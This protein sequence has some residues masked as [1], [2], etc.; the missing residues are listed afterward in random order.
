[1]HGYSLHHFVI[2]NDWNHLP[3]P[4]FRISDVSNILKEHKD[5]IFTV[6]TT[7]QPKEKLSKERESHSTCTNKI[8]SWKA[9]PWTKG[10]TN[11]CG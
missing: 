5:L 9:K 8:I 2:T 11:H 3:F 6:K 1:M 10:I 7:K 4:Q